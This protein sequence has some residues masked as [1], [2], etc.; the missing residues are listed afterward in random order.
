MNSN[1]ENNQLKFEK[2]KDQIETKITSYIKLN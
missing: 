1:I 2:I